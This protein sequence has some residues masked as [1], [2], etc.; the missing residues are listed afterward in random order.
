MAAIESG[1][2]GQWMGFIVVLAILGVSA[3]A[4]AMGAWWVAGLALSVAVGTAAVCNLGTLKGR[5]KKQQG[6]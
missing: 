1:T 3:F 4:I 6:E 2:L 5:D